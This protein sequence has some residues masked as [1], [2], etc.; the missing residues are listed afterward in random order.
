MTN[1]ED[2]DKMLHKTAFHQGLHCLLSQNRSLEK[3]ILYNFGNNRLEL[4]EIFN[5]QSR[6]TCNCIKL[7][8]NFNQS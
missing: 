4:F 6:L 2:A 5:V 1:S 3:K 7:Y 8:E